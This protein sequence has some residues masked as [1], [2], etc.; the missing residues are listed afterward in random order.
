MAGEDFFA[1]AIADCD[2]LLDELKDML[3]RH[4]NSHPR[5]L[6]RALGPN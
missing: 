6:Q 3:G 5:H 1:E 4:H 2:P